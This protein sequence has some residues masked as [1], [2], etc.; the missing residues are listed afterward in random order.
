MPRESSRLPR[1]VLLL[2][3]AVLLCFGT[4][5]AH[6]GVFNPPGWSGPG[7]T[8]GGGGGGKGSGG[9][10]AAPGPGPSTPGGV[11]GGVPS[12]P[13][14]PVPGPGGPPTSPSSPGA[15]PGPPKVA[16]GTP[17]G[18]LELLDAIS[19]ESWAL[20]WELSRDPW[21]DVRPGGLGVDGDERSSADAGRRP[22]P[23]VVFGQVVPALVG[24]VKGDESAEVTAAALLALARIGQDREREGREGYLPLFLEHV[25][26]ANS[27]VAESALIGLGVLGDPAGLPLLAEIVS[28]EKE[29]ARRRAIAAL[30][31]G[32]GA[33]RAEHEDGRRFAVGVLTRVLDEGEPAELHAAC[34]AALGVGGGVA[35]DPARHAAAAG[36]KRRDTPI[37]SADLQR[38]VERLR[39]VLADDKRPNLVRAQAPIALARLVGDA[40]DDLRAAVVGE[41]TALVKPRV[42]AAREV[43]RAAT[44][45][46]GFAAS[47]GDG[48]ADRAA[49]SALAAFGAD[50]RDG[51]AARR[52]WIALARASA[53][54][55]P[56]QLP[57]GDPVSR[58]TPTDD[59]IR[60]A[61]EDVLA[62]TRR[63][64]LR[65]LSRARSQDEQWLALAVG[66]L[67]RG[68]L[69]RGAEPSSDA[70]AA[71]RELLAGARG[72]AETAAFAV[73]LGLAEDPDAGEL[74]AETLAET[75]TESPRDAL[76]L[77]LGMIGAREHSG[78]LL[79]QIRGATYRPRLLSEAAIGLGL[80]R[81]A[82]AVDALCEG[83][84]EARSLAS[85]AAYAAALGKV[86]DA[87]AVEPLLD[88]LGEQGRTDRARA[89]AAAALGGVADRD[90]L[91]WN[92]RM[93]LGVDPSALPS[94]LFD[95]AGFGV[96]NLL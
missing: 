31:L 28:N 16:P 10:G 88:M 5:S 74:L 30:A 49:R 68:A 15:A 80:M 69:E 9:G 20:W 57:G 17:G 91:P 75:K 76:S 79:R 36:L 23:A 58:A 83:L 82:R 73:A 62:A 2:A 55:A 56:R 77:A 86:G 12:S 33:E 41:L 63:T 96:L 72:A 84:R 43:Q 39:E 27:E 18:S 46:L 22:T 78:L 1:R 93:K 61:E 44:I 70:R 67:E 14:T 89:F 32:L 6:G 50:A 94:V 42:K 3:S 85:Q 59:E 13:S 53:R 66:V 40:P 37:A 8:T 4:A 95:G 35:R 90:P 54:P 21:L 92:T 52:A 81:D 65:A 19:L 38:V 45:A 87:R 29:P 71:L 48:D 24:I 34:V 7:D 11:P 60:A 47:A 51:Y 26:A 25:G 64:L